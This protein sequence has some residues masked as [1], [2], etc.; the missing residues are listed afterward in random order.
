MP[1]CPIC[2]TEYV[3]EQVDTCPTCGWVLRLYPGGEEILESFSAES[4]A[5]KQVEAWGK[6]MWEASQSQLSELSELH[7]EL[8]RYLSADTGQL[9]SQLQESDWEREQLQTQLE[10]LAQEQVSSEH[11]QL[12][13][14]QLAAKL[15]ELGWQM[16]QASVERQQLQSEFSRLVSPLEE[17][18]EQIEQYLRA[19]SEENLL[20]SG[21]ESADGEIEPVSQVPQIS[22][23]QSESVSTDKELSLQEVQLVE[24]Y[25]RNP[26][27]LSNDATEV[28]AT[29][30]SMIQRDQSAVMEINRRGNY[31]I[32]PLEGLN[33]LVPKRNIMI[34]EYN[35]KTVEKM[36][37]C[38]GYQPGESKGFQLLK[39]ARVSPLSVGQMWQLEEPGI[40]QFKAR[41]DSI[42]PTEREIQ[43]IDRDPEIP[44]IKSRQES[45]NIIP[46]W[47]EVQAEFEQ[48]ERGTAPVNQSTETP[49]SQSQQL[50]DELY[51]SPEE[52]DLVIAYNRNPGSLSKRAIEVLQ[53]E[54]SVHNRRLGSS[55]P[56]VLEKARRWGHYWILMRSECNYLVPRVNVKI[57]ELNYMMF[58]SLFE[59]RGYQ[60]GI[61]R[62][63]QLVKPAR[64]EANSEKGNW[65]LVEPGILQ[66]ESN[67]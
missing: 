54:E 19:N 50:Q 7:S 13:L 15:D 31:W 64:V 9:Q 40:L 38:R 45:T 48:I 6:Q 16:Q 21:T 14:S 29:A 18:L 63:F 60:P 62:N 25:N 5:L 23:S 1:K 67:K 33:Y 46:S 37:E 22:I 43:P 10:D 58:E 12:E 55:E 17:R 36:F 32:I 59:C 51:L 65:Q 47:Q 42:D 35:S 11:P 56:V 57:N 34:N 26:N 3:E 61:Y 39:P 20:D 49:E 44:K 52:T 30:E 66:F 41:E 4:A 24:A 27:S 53:T 2:E 28:S 8:D